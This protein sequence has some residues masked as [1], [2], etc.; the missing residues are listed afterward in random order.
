MRTDLIECIKQLSTEWKRMRAASVGAKKFEQ[1]E[2][3]ADV[4][5]DDSDTDV[6]L[7]ETVGSSKQSKSARRK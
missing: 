4:K 1:F 7:V 2:G 6:E 3:D 5:M